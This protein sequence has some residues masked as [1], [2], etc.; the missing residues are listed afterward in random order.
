MGRWPWEKEQAKM[1]FRLLIA[2]VSL[3][4][5][6]GLGPDRVKKRE[7]C[8]TDV[9]PRMHGWKGVQHRDPYP[10]H[11]LG[12]LCAEESKAQTE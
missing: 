8:M 1:M 2:S 12:H 7:G 5:H 10:G 3:P 6:H 4:C 9:F 11:G